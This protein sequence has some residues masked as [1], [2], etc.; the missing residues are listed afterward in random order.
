MASLS[1]L[2]HL[3]KD[4]M[5][6]IVRETF[7]TLSETKGDLFT[8][9]FKT[10]DGLSDILDSEYDL[11]E[12]FEK[13]NALDD[14][15]QEL[16]KRK[17][18]DVPIQSMLQKTEC[19]TSDYIE[20][21]KELIN[22]C[23]IVEANQTNIKSCVKGY[24]ESMQKKCNDD[25]IESMSVTYNLAGFEA[26][27]FIYDVPFC[28]DHSVPIE[29]QSADVSG[30]RIVNNVL[31]SITITYLGTTFDLHGDFVF[32][33]EVDEYHCL[34]RFSKLSYYDTIALL[35]AYNGDVRDVYSKV[36][37]DR[38][39]LEDYKFIQTTLQSFDFDDSEQKMCFDYYRFKKAKIRVLHDD[40]IN[41]YEI[42][43]AYLL[44]KQ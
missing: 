11:G 22:F 35:Q 9:R 6:E 38:D 12:I 3:S 26:A 17:I 10:L 13:I 33:E 30:A 32:D 43:K 31:F 19:N 29:L 1:R 4:E 37:L 5:R 21:T 14:D 44:S 15:V 42:A 25:Q 23:S 8:P 40:T 41:L 16:I 7:E 2:S 34:L 36:N 39:H 28:H 18:I 20:L 24:K 27:T